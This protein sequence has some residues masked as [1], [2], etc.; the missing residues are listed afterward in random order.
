MLEQ[1]IKS[2]MAYFN[3][4]VPMNTYIQRIPQD[5]IYPLYVVTKIDIKTSFINSFY[6]MNH[7]TM[8]V[9]M[10]SKD[11][12]TL[13]NNAFDLNTAVFDTTGVIPILNQDGSHSG[14]AVRIEDIEVI[15]ITSDVNELYCMELNFKFDTTFNVSYEEFQKITTV[16]VNPSPGSLTNL[17]FKIG[18]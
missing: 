5:A 14:R 3:S 17:H 1:F 13:K 6:F 15:E 7:I 8:Y 4:I 16:H 10:W 12:I 18:T 2:I 9:Q 11:E